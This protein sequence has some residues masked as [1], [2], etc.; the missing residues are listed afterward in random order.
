MHKI[1]IVDDDPNIRA[2][3]RF[4]LERS[5]YA[6]QIA[7]DGVEALNM[8]LPEP[9]DLIILDL[10]LPKM[11]GF[12]VLRN[13]KSN[14]PTADIPVIVLTARATHACRDMSRAL[15]AAEFV[16]KPFRLRHLVAE[17][18][19]LLSESPGIA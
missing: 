16:S 9:P 13:L 18:G 12:E 5:A 8:A 7:R 2:V 17:I 19:T 10:M 4:G 6:V 15:G 3:L 1:M 14:R 11:D